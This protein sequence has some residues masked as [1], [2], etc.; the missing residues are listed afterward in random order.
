VS[1]RDIEIALDL[2]EERL[3]PLRRSRR[4]DPC[5]FPAKHRCLGQY[6]LLSDTLRLNARY[7]RPLD[8]EQA[9]ALLDTL[10]HELLHR[11]CGWFDQLR[12]TFLAHPHICAKANAAALRLKDE[13]ISRRRC[14]SMSPKSDVAENFS[15]LRVE[16]Y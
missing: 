13:F 5:G 14:A 3:P 6:R 12:D 15:R 16:R 1:L 10:V 7:L 4:V 8:E 9:V 11:H 2:I